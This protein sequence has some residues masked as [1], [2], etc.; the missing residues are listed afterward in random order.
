MLEMYDVF[1]QLILEIEKMLN[2][3]YY[4]FQMIFSSEQT[5]ELLQCLKELELCH[6]PL[7][8][9]KQQQ[10]NKVNKKT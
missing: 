3:S 1:F 6:E 10:S 5:F 8:K 4:I 7:T 9:S 2:L